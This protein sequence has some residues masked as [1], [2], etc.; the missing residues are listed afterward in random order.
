MIPTYEY[1]EVPPGYAWDGA[2]NVLPYG[3]RKSHIREARKIRPF[4]RC[5][6]GKIHTAAYVGHGSVCVCGIHLYKYMFNNL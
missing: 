3:V 4:F 2:A 1:G 6:C 5:V